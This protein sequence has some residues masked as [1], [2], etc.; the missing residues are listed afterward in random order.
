MRD[1]VDRMGPAEYPRILAANGPKMLALARDATDGAKPT[2]VPPSFTA[3][4]REVL[5]PDKL[6]VVGLAV[7]VDDDADAARAAATTLVQRTM[8]FPA[9]PYRAN[10]ARQGYTAEE[11]DTGAARLVDDVIGFGRPE[12]IAAQAQRH[13]DAGADHVILTTMT[14]NFGTG[15]DLLERVAPA[16]TTLT[17][18][19]LAA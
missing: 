8:N 17:R 11:L 2:M 16:V 1:Y 6:L 3:A 4:A 15:I 19:E 9:S 18:K 12:D 5:G 14:G 7:I 10:L 13:L